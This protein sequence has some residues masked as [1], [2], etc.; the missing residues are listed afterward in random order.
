MVKKIVHCADIHLRTYNLHDNFKESVNLFVKSIKRECKGYSKD[1]IR[2]VI[3]GDLVHQKITIS[4]EQLVLLGK[5]L[6][7]LSKLGKVI[8]VPGN[9]DLL[10]N[11]KDRMDSITPVVN[12]IDDP[13]VVYYLNSGFYE[14]EN[15]IWCNFSLYDNEVLDV[16]KHRKEN[17]DFKDKTYIS[18]FHG[19][20]NGS[21]TDIGYSFENNNNLSTFFGSDIVIMGDIHKRQTFEVLEEANYE[22]LTSSQH[23]EIGFIENGE[24]KLT[25][26]FLASY[27]GSFYQNDFGESV[28]KHGYL[29]WDVVDKCYTEID[30]E[31]TY[32]FYQFKINNINDFENDKEILTNDI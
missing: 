5:F 21:V 25:K 8:I 29:L 19:A 30:L 7:V 18:L 1:E 12:F 31:T 17:L 6:K 10:E 4:N 20:I 32:G 26:K 23:K 13:D 15:I 3:A 27:S 28:N 2:I 9:H 11:N 24:G 14:D 16:R 22:Y